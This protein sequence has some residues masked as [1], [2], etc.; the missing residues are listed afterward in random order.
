[1]AC[2]IMQCSDSVEDIKLKI[3]FTRGKM[4]Q[5]RITS[6]RVGLNMLL[7]IIHLSLFEIL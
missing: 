6:P 5:G 1:M 7:E 3:V 4:A 2:T